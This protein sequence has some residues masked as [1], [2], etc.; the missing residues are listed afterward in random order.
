MRLFLLSA[1]FFFSLQ[2]GMQALASPV[3][4]PG[5]GR[6]L[7]QDR[8]SNA[9]QFDRARSN[10]ESLSS[11]LREGRILIHPG[12][13][14]PS[15]G[16][17]IPIQVRVWTDKTNYRDGDSVRIFARTNRSAYLYIFST[18]PEGVTRQLFPNP[19]DRDN[20]LRGGQML[21]LPNRNYRLGAY[22][23][24]WDRIQAIAVDSRG[25]YYSPGCFHQYDRSDPFPVFHGGVEQAKREIMNSVRSAPHVRVEPHG[26]FPDWAFWWGEAKTRIYVSQYSQRPRD[27]REP[28]RID[29]K[30]ELVIETEPSGAGVYIDG[31]LRG[32]TPLTLELAEDAYDIRLV[33]PRYRIHER[34]IFVNADSTVKL[35][36]D[37]VRW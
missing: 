14:C 11:G 13:Y 1:L 7:L 3:L 18:D 6:G 9:E 30:G 15:P 25:K 22:G 5:K 37:L 28:D 36:Y 32:K 34:E 27:H 33:K 17:R 10:S 29:S 26:H 4:S 16:H 19:Y 31:R 24:G 2:V 20:Y 12:P 23:H 8:P 21:R 35:N